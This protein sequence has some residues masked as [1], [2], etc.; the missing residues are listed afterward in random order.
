M[1]DLQVQID[2]LQSK[3]NNSER[4]KGELKKYYLQRLEQQ[5]AHMT[6]YW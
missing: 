2:D 4:E 5:Q 1:S 6:H 3:L